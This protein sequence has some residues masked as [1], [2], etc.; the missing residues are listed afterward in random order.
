MRIGI[1]AACWANARGYGRYARE[2]LAAMVA[3]APDDEFLF[4]LDDRAAET[5]DLGQANVRTVRVRQHRS[6]T[7]AASA[8]SNRSPGDMLRFTR[9]V[10]AEKPD[11]FFSPS[12]YTYFPLPLGQRTV[13]AIH[14]AIAERYPHLTLPSLRARM[15]WR[16]KVWLALRQSTLVLTVSDFAR[17]EIVEVL[18]VAPERMRVAVEAPAQVYRPQEDAARIAAAARRVG[19]PEG[20][21]W[22]T[23]VGGFNP[24]KHVDAIVRAHARVAQAAPEPPPHLVLVGPTSEDGFHSH[25]DEVRQAVADAGTEALVHWAGYLPD[26]DLRDLHSG[27]RGLLLLSAS[28]GFGLPAVEAAACGCAVVATT[29]SPL[30]TLL[31]GG[32]FFV[33]PA[34]VTAASEAMVALLTDAALRDRMG[35]TARCRAA[36]LSWARAAEVALEALREAAA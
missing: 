33:A 4:F 1:D 36:E 34:D 16:A 27:A 9:A 28:E 2:L 3:A 6:P 20:A 21:P 15:F 22:F 25:L 17:D 5:F 7:E 23:Y 31:E 8:D 13:V 10:G 32:G 19:V 18:G 12:V 29:A 24:H 35:D 11:V 14:D 30:P 26:E